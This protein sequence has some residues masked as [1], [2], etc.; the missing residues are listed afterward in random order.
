MISFKKGNPPSPHLNQKLQQMFHWK[1]ISGKTAHIH[2][3]I[4]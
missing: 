4:C 2:L 1:F 3:P